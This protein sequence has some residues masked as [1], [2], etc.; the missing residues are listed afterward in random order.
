MDVNTILA[1]KRSLSTPLIIK[2]DMSPQERAVESALLKERWSLI[3]A[4]H[5]RKLIIIAFLS[6]ANY[7]EKLSMHC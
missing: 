2:P 7:M 3:N 6:M 1:N 4:G 5:N